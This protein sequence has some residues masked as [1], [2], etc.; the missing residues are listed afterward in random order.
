[1]WLVALQPDA[2][3]RLESSLEPWIA[4]HCTFPN[5]M[6]DR[7]TPV[8]TA[9]G[10]RTGCS[11]GTAS[12]IVGR[13]SASRSVSGWSRTTSPTDGRCWEDVGVIFTDDVHAWELYK[14]R[15]LNAAHSSMAYLCALVG[16]ERVRRGDGDSDGRWLP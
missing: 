14:L 16:V 13:L 10:T 7:I 8:T 9:V 12:S 4:D 15:L 2:R 5:S 11:A 6:V 1:M 3:R